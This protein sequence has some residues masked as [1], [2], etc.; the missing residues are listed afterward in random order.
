MVSAS[1]AFAA[2]PPKTDADGGRRSA[3]SLVGV[4]PIESI[5]LM[6]NHHE[7]YSAWRRAGFKHRVLVHLDAHL[8][9]DWIDDRD[10]AALL[11]SPKLNEVERLL[12]A[13]PGWN[14]PRRPAEQLI[15][16]GN[17]LYPAINDG[18]VRTLFWVVP[19]RVMESRKQR[20]GLIEVFRDRRKK[21]PLAVGPIEWS[22]ST[23]VTR[24]CGCDV[25]ACRLEDL[26]RIEEAVL[27]DIDADYLVVDSFRDPYPHADPRAAF[28]WIWPD[29]LVARLARRNVVS[30]FVTIPYSVEGGFTPLAF[31]F[32][33]DDLRTVLSQPRLSRQDRAVMALRR[34]AVAAWQRGE[35][36][37]ALAACE[38]AVAFREH[39]PAT[40][41]HLAELYYAKGGSDR[42]GH[43]Y[44]RAVELDH[45]YRWSEARSSP[46]S[47]RWGM[48][49]RA[50]AEYEKVLV[51]DPANADAHAGVGSLWARAGDW[52]RAV[53]CYQQAVAID[54]AHPRAQYDLGFIYAKRRKWQAAEI[55]LT[56]AVS[57]R[58][59]EGLAWFWLAYVY[60]KTRRREQAIA[61][62]ESAVR[63]RV[64]NLP[65][66]W[67]LG[68]LYLRSGRIYRAT[69]QYRRVLRMLPAVPLVKV[70]RLARRLRSVPRR[71]WDAAARPPLRQ[72]E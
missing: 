61:A 2:E 12:A 57:A 43:H 5:Q 71:V 6:E 48:I 56:Q 20:N 39:D 26:P 44:R 32:L 65:L 67:H 33:A 72:A 66:C 1:V 55:A 45:R 59:Y 52:D 54:P 51:L 30:D 16:I 37:D 23:L 10:P 14:L 19:D 40:H 29:E 11:E 25:V 17:Y 22:G 47:L 8:D 31:R 9:F 70:R 68:S 64:R 58:E 35:I 42:A 69:R 63:A 46:V 24:L 34:S 18:L 27:L 53:R 36:D 49:E 62:Y 41:Y 3:G 7:A 4:D 28:P 15:D 60:R 38:R 50:S 13:G 21:R